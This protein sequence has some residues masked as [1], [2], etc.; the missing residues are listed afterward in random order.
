MNSVQDIMSPAVIS[1]GADLTLTQAASSLEKH[2]ISGAPVTNNNG[3]FLGVLSRS[4]IAFEVARRGRS[5]RTFDPDVLEGDLPVELEGILVREV[6]TP[7]L[8]RISQHA[9][10]EELAH[11]LLIAGVHRLLVVDGEDQVVGL[12]TTTDL[13]RSFLSQ[14]PSQGSTQPQE[15][16][17]KRRPYLF[18]I[19]MEHDGN[20]VVARSPAGPQLALQPPVEFGGNGKDWT[21]EDLFVTSTA[22]CLCLTFMEMARGKGLQ[23]ESYQARAI[24]RLEGDGT[25]LRFRRIDLYPRIRVKGKE[26]AVLRTLEQAKLRCLVGRSSDVLVALHPKIEEI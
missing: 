6:M 21:P 13:I 20:G 25:T 3:D 16:R 14:S 15:P 11:A 9:S 12:V 19:E 5:A 7:H 4:D 2:R 17:P 18:E 23:V 22:S 24:G 1:I 8:L 10:L 26:D